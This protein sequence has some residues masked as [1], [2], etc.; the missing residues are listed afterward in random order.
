MTK[1]NTAN[2]APVNSNPTDKQVK[3]AL[4]RSV[5][6]PTVVEEPAPEKDE[7]TTETGCPWL[8]ELGEVTVQGAFK[9][10]VLPIQRIAK[11][12]TPAG[13]L[14]IPSNLF[15]AK[16]GDTIREF[17]KVGQARKWLSEQRKAERIAKSGGKAKQF[18]GRVT[19]VL[20]KLKSLDAFGSGLTEGMELDGHALTNGEL[21]AVECRIQDAIQNIEEV[22]DTLGREVTTETE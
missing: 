9:N 22:L 3:K 13:E 8:D 4:T 10:G 2:K 11:V 15:A 17:M 7:V 12:E 18:R 1:K 20:N 21:D 16:W 6:K 5:P 19:T 14:E